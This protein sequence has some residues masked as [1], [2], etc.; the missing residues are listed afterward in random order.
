MRKKCR[1]WTGCFLFVCLF[2]ISLEYEAAA[3]WISLSEVY[4]YVLF[5]LLNG[6]FAENLL[7]NQPCTVK[8]YF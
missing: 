5:L 3:S 8:M 1:Q 6:C 4:L 7:G 2:F